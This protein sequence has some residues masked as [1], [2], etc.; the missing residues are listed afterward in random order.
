[1]LKNISFQVQRWVIQKLVD[2]V[3]QI[4]I[5]Q[6][7]FNYSSWHLSITTKKNDKKVDFS[8]NTYDVI[9]N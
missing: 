1:M 4:Y 3:V 2:I 5:I 6:A 7:Y 9:P 8:Y